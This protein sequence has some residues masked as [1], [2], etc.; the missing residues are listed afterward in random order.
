METPKSKKAHKGGK[1][2]RTKPVDMHLFD[3]E[4]ME[5]RPFRE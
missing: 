4:P 1:I 3:T 5:E 2:V